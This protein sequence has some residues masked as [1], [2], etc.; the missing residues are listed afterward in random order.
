MLSEDESKG[1]LI[2]LDHAIDTNRTVKSGAKDRT[3]TAAFMSIRVLD[4]DPD[5]SHSFMDDL[6]SIFWLFLW[7]CIHHTGPGKMRFKTSLKD[8]NKV[9][10]RQ[11]MANKVAIIRNKKS[12]RSALTEVTSYCAPLRDH[13]ENLWKVVFPNCTEW[14]KED[15]NLPQ[16]MIRILDAAKVDLATKGVGVDSLGSKDT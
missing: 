12:F 4:D 7:L 13:I 5:H 2:D 6:E 15:D 11:L 16:E 9:T 14:L 3:G 10:A 1:F 8:W